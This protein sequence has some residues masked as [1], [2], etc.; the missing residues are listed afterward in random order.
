MPVL[1]AGLFAAWWHFAVD[2]A[3]PFWQVTGDYS[4]YSLSHAFTLDSK[5]AGVDATNYGY[6]VHPGLVYGVCAFLA[7]R[8]STLGVGGLGERIEYAFTH[9]DNYWLCANVASLVLVLGGLYLLWRLARRR[10]APFLLGAGCFFALPT[11]FTSGLTGFSNDSLALPYVAGSY[12]L[13]RRGL[14]PD[15]P[16][17]SMGINWPRL[18]VMFGLGCLA[19]VG[20]GIKVYFLSPAL[21]LAVGLAVAAALGALSWRT[22]CRCVL[23]VIV[24]GV[25]A[26][27]FL[28]TFIQGWTAFG[29]WINWNWNM[30]T[31]TGRYGSG[32]A[33]LAGAQQVTDALSAM[34]DHSNAA[35]PL[36]LLVVIALGGWALVLSRGDR[37]E[38]RR[39]APL[40]IAVAAGMALNMLGALK[41]Y[42]DHYMIIV[43][44]SLACLVVLVGLLYEIP[45]ARGSRQPYR[46]FFGVPLPLLPV[47]VALPAFLVL[48]LADAAGS[49]ALSLQQAKFAAKDMNTIRELP[50]ADDEQ[51]VWAYYTPS[52]EHGALLI[53]NYAG[54]PLVRQAAGLLMRPGDILAN[55]SANDTR[56][57]YVLFPK[58]YY[59]DRETITERARKAFDFSGVDF[60]LRPTDKIIE[61]ETVFVLSRTPDTP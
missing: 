32:T 25:A 6:R 60:S 54:S 36:L 9:A 11:V 24:G 18:V 33:G 38:L 27:L 30:L 31:H 46:L 42:Q 8:L 2:S 5:L 59:P 58:R 22:V 1:L 51:R 39:S 55:Y 10:L 53:S 26:W 19:A 41:H 14:A 44:A 21:G 37:E 43:S 28:V 4:W 45:P 52:R 23:A 12:L 7:Y 29:D 3:I 16:T 61:L 40:S 47:V 48:S 34:M 35:M 20:W 17:S 56:W 50:L 15:E 57:R 13:L 49:H